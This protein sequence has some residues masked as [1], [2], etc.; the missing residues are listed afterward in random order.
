M[1][2]KEKLKFW[3]DLK[4]F[5]FLNFSL[6]DITS[7]LMKY[8]VIFLKKAEHSVTIFIIYIEARDSLTPT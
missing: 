7:L 3:S 6:Y 1:I 2:L 5:N 4:D 8:I